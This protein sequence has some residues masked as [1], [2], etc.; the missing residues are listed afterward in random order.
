M[1]Q[2]KMTTTQE[3]SIEHEAEVCVYLIW[4]IPWYNLP[5][6]SN[7]PKSNAYNNIETRTNPLQR[8]CLWWHSNITA[9]ACV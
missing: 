9:A 8:E 6:T 2:R 1:V 3:A 5:K 4:S 7:F